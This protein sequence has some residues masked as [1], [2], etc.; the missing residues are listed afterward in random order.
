MPEPA[1]RFDGVTAGYGAAPV[2][3]DVD[4]EVHGGEVVGVIGPNG[5]GKTTL[6]RVASRGLRPT[7]GSVRILGRDPYAMRARQAAQLVAVVPQDMAPVF[8][9]T[10]LEVALM[11]RSPHGSAWRLGSGEDWSFVRAAMATTGIEDIA[12]RPIEE[13]SGGERR[14]VILA[15][16]LAQDAPVL[17]LDEPTTHLDLHHVLELLRVMRHLADDGRAVLAIFHDLNVAAATCD[18]VYALDGGRV[19]AQGRPEDVVTPELLANVYGVT[20][21]VFASPTTGRP[22]VALVGPNGAGPPSATPGA[23][24]EGGNG[25]RTPSAGRPTPPT[26][27]PGRG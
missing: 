12:D 20:A 9:F 7:A 10:A 23:G 2:V 17:L 14:R 18:R 16:A 24:S 3:R 25:A 26:P 6:V 8:S 21:E 5:S 1:L 15:Q 11:G 22:M 19:A 13:L 4:L 27:A